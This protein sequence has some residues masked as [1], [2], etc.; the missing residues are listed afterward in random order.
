MKEREDFIDRYERLLT[1]IIGR[2][3]EAKIYVMSYYPVNAELDFGTPHMKQLFEVRT[4][5]RISEANKRIEQLAYKLQLRFI[6]INQGITDDKG[7]LKQE[8]SIEGLHMYANGYRALLDDI[9]RY[10]RD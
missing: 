4:N 1:C 10:V 2:L 7:N 9:M 3:P 6:N 5:A 8:Y